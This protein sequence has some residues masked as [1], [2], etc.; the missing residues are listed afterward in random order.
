[1]RPRQGGARNFIRRGIE[2]LFF[3][4]VCMRLAHT[5]HD[6]VS[7]AELE[8][9]ART[10]SRSWRSCLSRAKGAPEAPVRIEGGRRMRWSF[11]HVHLIASDVDRAA[12]FYVR[13]FGAAPVNRGLVSGQPQA[14]LDLGGTLL[15]IRGLRP[16]DELAEGKN[17]RIDHF[18]VR[19]DDMARAAADLKAKGARFTVEPTAF[20]P[21][22]KIAF[23]EGPDGVRIELLE[24]S[25]PVGSATAT[26]PTGI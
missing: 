20:N 14:W 5:A 25:G 4:T 10:Y 17:T 7:I 13:M 8:T 12:D 16:A 19:V 15:I 21:T 1:V 6:L 23:I 3:G 18:G 2:A 11:D 24:R 9:A 26:A 22:T